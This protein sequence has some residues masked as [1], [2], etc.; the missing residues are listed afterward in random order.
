MENESKFK[1]WFQSA[2]DFINE[3]AWFQEAKTKWEELDPKSKMYLRFAGF[4]IS[5]L[6]VLSILASVM[7][8]VHSLKGDLLEKRALLAM[9][10]NATDEMRRL[11]ENT[12][13]G[14]SGAGASNT[15]AAGGW[16]GY[17]ETIAGSAGVDKAALGIS[18]DKAGASSDQSKEHLFELGLK[19]VN[20]KQI[21]RFAFMLESGQ[22]PVKLRNLTIDTKS[23]RSGYLDAT[24]A[25]SA[26]T[27]VTPK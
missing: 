22:R 4:G 5:V 3:Q 14:A 17:F 12:P 19:H 11:R 2:V 8:S 15:D 24:L 25:V 13:S 6:A 10:Q 26:F 20:I 1:Q 21:T 7:W 23:D 16:N 9:V 18:V 27:L